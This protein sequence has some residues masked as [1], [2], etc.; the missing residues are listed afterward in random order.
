MA[1]SSSDT[2]RAYPEVFTTIPPP[3]TEKK[4]GQLSAEQI[5]QFYDEGYVIVEDYFTDEE[6]QPCKDAI[7]GLVEGL[8]QKLYDGG[9]IDKMYREF[10]LFQRLT[11]LNKAF[12]GSHILMFKQGLLP[13]AFQEL[14]C[15]EK[16]LNMCEQFIGPDVACHPVWNLRAKPPNVDTTVVPWHQDSAYFCEESYDHMIMIAWIPFLDTD[17][18]NGGMQVMRGSQKKGVVAK[19]TCGVGDTWFVDLSEEEMERTMGVDPEN[20]VITCHVPYRGML[21][22][23]NITA[24]RS[25]HNISNDVRWSVDLRWQSPHDKWGFYNIAEGIPFKTAGKPVTPDWKKFLSVNRKEVW[26]KRHYK[27]VLE[28][29]PFDTTVTGPWFGRWDIVSDNRH[30]DAFRQA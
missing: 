5:R 29:D 24:H 21:L 28:A 25:V 3:V 23:N 20:D 6:L 7:S 15:N 13:E 1:E 14:W 19:H 22:F 17:A 2:P 26:Q 4:I 8:A 18:N 16:L 27:K 30:T 12:P 10:G 9:K 11:E